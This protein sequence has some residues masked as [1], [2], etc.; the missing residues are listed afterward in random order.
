MFLIYRYE[1]D[2]ILVNSVWDYYLNW[3]NT[4]A[5]KIYENKTKTKNANIQLESKKNVFLIFGCILLN[6][7]Y[8]I[9]IHA[10]EI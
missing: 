9:P 3:P 10:L 7:K 8:N 4:M 5:V 6:L 1:I 2:F